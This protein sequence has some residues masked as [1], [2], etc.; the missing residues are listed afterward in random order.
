MKMT[1]MNVILAKALGGLAGPYLIYAVLLILL[2]HKYSLENYTSAPAS[3][4]LYFSA[5][6]VIAVV[7]LLAGAVVASFGAHSFIQQLA[8]SVPARWGIWAGWVM[9]LFCWVIGTAV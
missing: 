8:I 1:S 6:M 5:L 7:A 9:V 3:F 2:R 4:H